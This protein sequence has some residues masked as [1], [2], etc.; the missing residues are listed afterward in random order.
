MGK[1][2][3]KEEATTAEETATSKAV[4]TAMSPPE[5]QA[6]EIVMSHS[7]VRTT[8]IFI[9]R[10][11]T[12]APEVAIT[13]VVT[14]ASARDLE[15]HFLPTF[16]EMFTWQLTRPLEKILPRWDVDEEAHFQSPLCTERQLPADPQTHLRPME[17]LYLGQMELGQNQT[18]T[19]RGPVRQQ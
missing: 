16:V 11:A 15:L 17:P 7:T 18:A 13:V 10:S 1:I 3:S 12:Q 8:E 2:T 19:A 5:I 9:E 6:V 4:R 14:T